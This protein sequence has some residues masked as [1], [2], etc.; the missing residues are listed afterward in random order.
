MK[1]SIAEPTSELY[2]FN[3]REE[4]EDLETYETPTVT[5]VADLR[6][7]TLASH[8]GDHLDAAFNAGTPL[9]HITIS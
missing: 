7:L 6:E 8:T 1:T 5:V 9:T 2:G 3:R 4:V